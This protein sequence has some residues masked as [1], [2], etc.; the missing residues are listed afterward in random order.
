MVSGEL[1]AHP[2]TTNYNVSSKL[3]NSPPILLYPAQIL[4]FVTGEGEKNNLQVRSMVR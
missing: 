2:A 3:H 4:L 1:A